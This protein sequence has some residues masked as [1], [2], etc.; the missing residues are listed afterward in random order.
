MLSCCNHV[1]F[2]L[3]ISLRVYVRLPTYR[4]PTQYQYRAEICLL[5]IHCGLSKDKKRLDQGSACWI[6]ISKSQQILSIE[7]EG[8]VTVSWS[9]SCPGTSLF[10]QENHHGVHVNRDCNLPRVRLSS[11]T[12][13][14][15]YPIQI[16]YW[17]WTETVKIWLRNKRNYCIVLFCLKTFALFQGLRFNRTF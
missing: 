7:R 14:H 8:G 16:Y 17:I 6:S 15:D 5:F 10:L 12:C 3:S 4:I 9:S 2:R 13:W 11:R 1:I